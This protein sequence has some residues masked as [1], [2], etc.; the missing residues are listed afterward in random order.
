MQC[1]LQNTTDIHTYNHLL[2]VNTKPHFSE[3]FMLLA[4]FF[5][6]LQWKDFSSQFWIFC[7]WTNTLY[8][9][10]YCEKLCT[11]QQMVCRMVITYSVVF[12]TIYSATICTEDVFPLE[13]VVFPVWTHIA[14]SCCN[15]KI[16]VFISDLLP[17]SSGRQ[18]TAS[19]RCHSVQVTH[20]AITSLLAF[21]KEARLGIF[22]WITL[23]T[24]EGGKEIRVFKP[25]SGKQNISFIYYIY[26]ISYYIYNIYN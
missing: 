17:L 21:I 9:I 3:P 12:V 18:R 10:F 15:R 13:V 8:Y 24:K 7:A 6:P 19:T 20:P 22:L 26:I 11:L 1:Y 2:H 5:E 14:M 23:A 4:L 16:S 25:N